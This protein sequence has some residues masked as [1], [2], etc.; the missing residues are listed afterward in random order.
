M[1][2]N[3]IRV[4]AFYV[5]AV[6]SIDSTGF[7]ALRS[8]RGELASKGTEIW[9][10][11]PSIRKRALVDEHADVLDVTLPRRFETYDDMLDAYRRLDATDQAESG[12][13]PS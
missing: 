10:I 11:N 12:N 8:V 3:G 13:P 7:S 4:I 9:V 2:N 5:A 6:P 1:A